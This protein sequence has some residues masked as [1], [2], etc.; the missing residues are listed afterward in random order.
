MNLI[1]NLMSSIAL[2]IFALSIQIGNLRGASVVFIIDPTQSQVTL[3]GNLEAFDKELSAPIT[4]QSSGSLTASYAGTINADVDETT[5][6]FTGSSL[7]EAETNDSPM[8]PA[9]GGSPGYGP[10]DY[11]GMAQEQAFFTTIS[12]EIALRNVALD[13]T[14]PMLTLTNG[15]FASTSLEFLFSS[16]V[17][18]TIDYD[19]PIL[20]ESGSTPLAGDSTDTSGTLASLTTTGNVQVLSIPVNMT[21]TDTS[22]TFDGTTLNMVGQIVATQTLL[23]PPII[24]SITVTNQMVVLTVANATTQSGVFTSTDLQTWSTQPASVATNLSDQIIFTFPLSG[25]SGFFRVK[26]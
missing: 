15:T 5:I 22:G 19:S 11:G 23:P 10:A 25:N 3:S 14:S 21:F 20:N 12:V 24:N 6:Q 16:N 13:L 26:Q 9:M 18:G 7:I 2:L 17:D 4:A 8:Q 1:K